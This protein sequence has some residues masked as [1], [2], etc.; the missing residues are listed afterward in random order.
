[1]GKSGSL[2]TAV[3][4]TNGTIQTSSEEAKKEILPLDPKKYGLPFISKLKPKSWKWKKGD[5]KTHHGFIFE[6]LKALIGKEDLGL[7]YDPEISEDG[8]TETYGGMNY[9]ALIA[10]MINA[11]QELSTRVEY[12]EKQLR[13]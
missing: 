10:P 9:S 4:A 11:I 2:Y 3:W 12:L 7:L 6:D 5:K 8:I 13:K 1:M